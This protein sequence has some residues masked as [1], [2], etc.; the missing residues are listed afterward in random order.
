M[1]RDRQIAVLASIVGLAGLIFGLVAL[2]QDS[3]ADDEWV[4]NRALPG[5]SAATSAAASA[6]ESDEREIREL[7]DR[8]ERLEEPQIAE[9]QDATDDSSD[10][11]TADRAAV[12]SERDDSDLSGT[13]V[14][15]PEGNDLE[16]VEPDTPTELDN[17]DQA[18]AWASQDEVLD[19]G[20][21]LPDDTSAA[22][23]GTLQSFSTDGVPAFIG[24]VKLGVSI[25]ELKF[26]LDYAQDSCIG[27][28]ALCNYSC[29]KYND[30]PFNFY[31]G[32]WSA[33]AFSHSSLNPTASEIS[34]I[35]SFETE[36]ISDKYLTYKLH[37][38]N[39]VKI[40]DENSDNF[41]SITIQKNN[42]YSSYA[43]SRSSPHLPWP[44]FP[45]QESLPL[46]SWKL[47]VGDGD[48]TLLSR[49]WITSSQRVL[50]A[51]YEAIYHEAIADGSGLLGNVDTYFDGEV[52]HWLG[53]D[54]HMYYLVPNW[55]SEYGH[56]PM[57]GSELYV[58]ALNDA[59]KKK[60]V[61]PTGQAFEDAFWQGANKASLVKDI[62]MWRPKSESFWGR[63]DDMSDAVPWGIDSHS[64]VRIYDG[65]SDEYHWALIT[66]QLSWRH[67]KD[68]GS[69][70]EDP[71]TNVGQCEA[72]ISITR[73]YE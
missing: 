62:E 1:S 15:A 4:R 23:D 39:V 5:D 65:I 47:E 71:E 69:S 27:L 34:D 21:R 41:P 20:Q 64:M 54:H 32:Q 14:A 10:G 72:N 61:V 35:V 45:L 22:Q 19:K 17:N 55:L 51:M 50:A 12:L 26:V 40:F 57:S 52:Y 18:G 29:R 30:D 3:G 31:A 67:D 43:Y 48:Y 38:P 46:E 33:G 70:L 63:M 24:H 42:K 44:E 36:T 8:L 73:S 49:P 13:R 66:A 60:W 58:K 37:C 56:V 6:S 28:R 7:S 59:V 53:W 68:D 9:P 2:S 11:T 16:R 25:P